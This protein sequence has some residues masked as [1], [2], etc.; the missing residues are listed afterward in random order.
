MSRALVTVKS[1]LA[2]MRD[3]HAVEIVDDALITPAAA[4][5]LATNRVQVRRSRQTVEVKESAPRLHLVGDAGCTRCQTLLSMLDRTVGPVE[6]RPCQGRREGLLAALKTMCVALAECD[7]RRGVVLVRDGAVA[8]AVANKHP[9][10]RAAI[11]T[12]AGQLT[13]LVREMGLNLLIIEHDAV[14]LRQA[15]ALI[16]TFAAGRASLEPAI[17][18]ALEGIA[19]P[20]SPECRCHNADR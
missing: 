6:F 9:A 18:A 15:R 19:A 4:E 20:S 16:E 11:V 1:L 3:G 14:S 17:A 2:Q 10:V 8:S 12:R 5:W 7:R 13:M